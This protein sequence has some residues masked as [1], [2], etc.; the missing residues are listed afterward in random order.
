MGK[1]DNGQVASFLP[2]ETSMVAVC[3]SGLCPTASLHSLGDAFVQVL[4]CFE[5]EN[6]RHSSRCLLPSQGIKKQLEWFGSSWSRASFKFQFS[7]SH[8]L[9]LLF[10]F[11]PRVLTLFFEKSHCICTRTHMCKCTL[12]FERQRVEIVLLTEQRH[13]RL[14]RNQLCSLSVLPKWPYGQK[15]QRQENVCSAPALQSLANSPC[16]HTGSLRSVT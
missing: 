9:L 10:S 11:L 1:G 3:S 14:L 13:H 2:L 7:Y 16:G 12:P 15:L 4:C 6:S 8:T 5:P